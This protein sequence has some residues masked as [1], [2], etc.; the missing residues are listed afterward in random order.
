MSDIA[1]TK[2][3]PFTCEVDVRLDAHLRFFEVWVSIA[4]D[5]QMWCFEEFLMGFGSEAE[6]NE[7]AELIRQA[8]R[9]V[10]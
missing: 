5:A 2:P 3:N 8:M 6:A 7:H 1:A 9:E 4:N 10:S